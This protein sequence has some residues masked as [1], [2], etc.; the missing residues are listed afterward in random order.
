[1]ALEDCAA[2]GGKN[3]KV[4]TTFVNACLAVAAKPGKAKWVSDDYSSRVLN[5]IKAE[6]MEDCG[7]DCEIVRQ[8]CAEP[9]RR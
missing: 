7:S 6:A 1:M 2:N 9:A 5:A 8:G 3:C 4:I